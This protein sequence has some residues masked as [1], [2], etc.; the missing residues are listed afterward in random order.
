[1]NPAPAKRPI[2][3]SSVV[4]KIRNA[5]FFISH[6]SM[7]LQPIEFL[8]PTL[9][10]NQPAIEHLVGDGCCNPVD[11]CSPHLR[12]A[13]KHCN[14]ILFLLSRRSFLALLLPQFLA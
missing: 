6:L 11:E 3:V 10:R 9:S 8:V 14:R 2:R 7:L 12:I 4:L 5:V 13:F 1:M